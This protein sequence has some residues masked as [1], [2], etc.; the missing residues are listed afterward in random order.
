MT[1]LI[2]IGAGL[3]GLFAA[4]HAAERGATVT[5]VALGRGGLALSHGCI[6]VLAVEPPLE[7]MSRLDKSHPYVKAGQK[8]LRSAVEQF[9]GWMEQEGLPYQGHLEQNLRLPTALGASHSTCLA[10]AAQAQGDLEG[11]EPVTLAGL[12]GFRDFSTSLAAS[13][14]ERIGVRVANS[15]ELPLPHQ[16]SVRDRYS[17]D[18]ARRFEDKAWREEV[19]RSWKTRLTGARRIGI[20]AC[21]GLTSHPEVWRDMHERLGALIFEIPTLPPSVPGLRLENALRNRALK[22]GVRLIE[23]SRALGQVDGRS[24]GRRAGGVVIHAAG[25]PRALQA[26]AVLLATGGFLHGG[27]VARQDG[28]AQESVFDLPV[29]VSGDR[30]ALTAGSPIEAQPYATLGLL[31]DS[32]MRP[33]G[34]R[35]KAVF[36]NVFAAGGLLAGSDRS[37]EGSRQGIDLASA[38]RAVESSLT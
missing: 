20:P 21:L 15:V 28:R 8:A 36:E 37:S 30:T 9:L 14:L 7:A 13:G 1:H 19:A 26:D 38:W 4:A 32:R 6:D 12:A 10:P 29:R 2:V 35:G 34:A 25:G 16:A 23:G 11:K 5:L 3:T 24:G 27:L 31:V 18:L 17:I 22:A 33:V